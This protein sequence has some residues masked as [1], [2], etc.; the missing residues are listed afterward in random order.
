MEH[1]A[2][3]YRDA[4]SSPV[5]DILFCAG[6]G[7]CADA[8]A[9]TALSIRTLKDWAYSFLSAPE[10]CTGCG[11]CTSVCPRLAIEMTGF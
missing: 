7:R 11:R 6:C 3:S 8:C 9:A 4:A 5:V 10:R 1:T 2:Q